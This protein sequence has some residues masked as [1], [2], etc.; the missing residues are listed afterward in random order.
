[1]LKAFHY[2]AFWVIGAVGVVAFLFTRAATPPVQYSEFAGGRACA[3]CHK[4]IYDTHIHTAHYH[5]SEPA[6]ENN[7]KG[8]FADGK[9]TFQFNDDEY[10]AM[11]RR[12]GRLY[13]VDY[14]HGKENLTAPIDITT[15]SGNRGQT[16]LYWED[17]R[18]FQLPISYFTPIDRWTN[19]P[20]YLNRA[21]FNRPITS[22]CLECHSTWFQKIPNSAAENEEFS[23]AEIIYGVDCEKCHGPGARHIAFHK[24]APQEKQARFIINPGKLT[25][26][27][28][29]DLCRLC[30]GGGLVKTKPSFS[31]LP[32]DTLSQFFNLP[33]DTADP[34]AIDVHG[35]QYGLLASSKC[36][37]NS[38]MTC[39]TCHNP[40]RNEEG[41]LAVY[42]AR[43]MNCHNPGH[44]N[45]CKLKNKEKYNISTNCIDC[46]MPEL[47]SKA[48]TVLQQG[49]NV[50]TP[51]SMRTHFI[52]VYPEQTKIFLSQK[53]K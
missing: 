15:G 47:T 9:N 43:C 4:D 39:G 17:N 31:F 3:S 45:F 20:G 50:P 24:N 10:I 35:N 6:N 25:R 8:S 32:G 12:N 37:L 16:Y 53:H 22:R 11:V 13:Q 28:N 1:M 42:S 49:E 5:T 18:L 40:H 51:A 48:I 26:Q 30:H 7:V 46:H 36:F 21:R 27:Q 44:N 34:H 23:R 41:M 19:S 29:L 38:Q 14:V 52:T 2:R 33:T